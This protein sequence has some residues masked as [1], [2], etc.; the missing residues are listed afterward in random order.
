[1]ILIPRYEKSNSTSTLSDEKSSVDHKYEV[2][3]AK[4]RS[5]IEQAILMYL[6][7]KIYINSSIAA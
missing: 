3:L 7:M 2:D 4:V 5:K 6:I 1:M